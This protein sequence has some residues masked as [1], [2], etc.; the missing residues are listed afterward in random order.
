MMRMP[1]RRKTRSEILT[2]AGLIII[3]LLV[4]APVLF[5]LAKSTQTRAEVYHFPPNLGFGSAGLFNYKVAWTQYDL[6]LYMKN[7]MIV[8]GVVMIFKTIFSMLGFNI[9]PTFSFFLTS[10]GRSAKM[11]TPTILSPAP[12]R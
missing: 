4:M 7:T 2:H 1:F 9:V 6:G 12:S 8:A 3:V 11:V 5:A 10:G